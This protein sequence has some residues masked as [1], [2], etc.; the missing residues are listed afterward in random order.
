[1]RG[2]ADRLGCRSLLARSRRP[3]ARQPRSRPGARPGWPSCRENIA[4][5]S[6]QRVA[7]GPPAPTRPRPSSFR[8]LPG[9]GTCRPGRAYGPVTVRGALSGRSSRSDGPRSG[10]S[11]SIAASSGARF[12]QS[13]PAVRAQPHSP[14]LLPPARPRLNPAIGETLANTADWALAEEAGGTPKSTDWL[15][16]PS[17]PPA[18]PLL[19]RADVPGVAALVGGRRLVRRAMELAKGD[20]AESISDTL[21][22]RTGLGPKYCEGHGRLQAPG[23][24]IFRSIRVPGRCLREVSLGGSRKTLR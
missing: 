15:P 5:G 11:C 16:A 21:A 24:D 6:V 7:T 3:I 2:L 12:L 13:Q 23:L 1:V 10:S 22:S 18:A 19:L 4:G 14:E 9:S 17:R 20:F 8:F